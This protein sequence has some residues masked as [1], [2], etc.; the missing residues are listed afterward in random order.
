MAAGQ[1]HL[2]VRRRR[3][4][5]DPVVDAD[6]GLVYLE[7]GN[8][9][10][11]YGGELRPGNNLFDNSVVALD[12]KTGKLRWYYQLVHHDI[13]EHDVSTHLVLYDAN[14]GLP[15]GASAAAGGTRKL[16]TAELDDGVGVYF[17][18]ENRKIELA[19]GVRAVTQNTS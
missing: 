5:D 11:Q 10:P 14:A 15:A 4:V 8:A 6:L 19:G 3:I 17:E 13:W 9:V 12:M 7:T 18:R 16:I 2:E 1:R